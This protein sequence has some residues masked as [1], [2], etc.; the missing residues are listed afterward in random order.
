MGVVATLW[1]LQQFVE[2]AK[3][4]GQTALEVHF[5]AFSRDTLVNCLVYYTYP[6]TPK[7]DQ[8]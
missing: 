6:F 7:S 2:S 4:W 8:F 1:L 3:S 5:I